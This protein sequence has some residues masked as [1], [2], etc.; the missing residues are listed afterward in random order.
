MINKSIL[1]IRLNCWCHNAY[2]IFQMIKNSPLLQV[3]LIHLISWSPC[4]SMDSGFCLIIL[5][6]TVY[7]KCYPHQTRKCQPD[8]FIVHTKQLSDT[9]AKDKRWTDISYL[10]FLFQQIFIDIGKLQVLP[11]TGVCAILHLHLY[12]FIHFSGYPSWG[13]LNLEPFCKCIQG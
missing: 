7:L 3:I 8:Q 2:H 11:I 9:R 4:P 5:K 10:L 6:V 1:D 12:L 13:I